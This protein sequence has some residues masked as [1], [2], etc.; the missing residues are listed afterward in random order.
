L[1]EQNFVLFVTFCLESVGACKKSSQTA[2]NFAY[3]ITDVRGYLR[4]R[5]EAMSSRE[6]CSILRRCF[7]SC[8]GSARVSRAGCGVPPQ[9]TFARNSD[10]HSATRRR[11]NYRKF[12]MARHHRRH[13]RR[14]CS[15]EYFEH[16]CS[17]HSSPF[18]SS[19]TIS[20]A[21]N[22]S[23]ASLR[24]RFRGGNSRTTEVAAGIV[25]RLFCCNRFTT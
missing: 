7:M 21:F 22:P 12:A 20:I 24:L 23:S 18:N 2:M 19:T 3:S 1:A 25:R 8:L 13:A 15:P 6:S 5:M 9:R 16:R 14:V 17:L 10:Y 11:E 4:R